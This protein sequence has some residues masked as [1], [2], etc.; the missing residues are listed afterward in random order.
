MALVTRLVYL[1]FTRHSL[2]KKPVPP[3][4]LDAN[5]KLLD[6]SCDSDAILEMRIGPVKDGQSL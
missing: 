6:E 2:G 1:E 3:A 5:S 4:I